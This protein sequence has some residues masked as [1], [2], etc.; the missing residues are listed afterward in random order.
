V[1]ARAVVQKLREVWS[2]LE[3]QQRD[4]GEAERRHDETVAR[5]RHEGAARMREAALSRHQLLQHVDAL[6]GASSASAG[7]TTAL[8]RTLHCCL[9]STRVRI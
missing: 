6:T 9:K 5:L 2:A 3:R 7:D 4:A 8:V 1:R